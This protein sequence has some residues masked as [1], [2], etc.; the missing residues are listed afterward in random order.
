MTTIQIRINEEIKREFLVRLSK[1][2]SYHL[3]KYIKF[4][5]ALPPKDCQRVIKFVEG[6][7]LLTIATMDP[8]HDKGRITKASL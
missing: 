2:M 4:L 5:I 3:R 1:G 8:A 7:D 6:N